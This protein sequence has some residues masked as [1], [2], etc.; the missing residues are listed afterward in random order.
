MGQAFTNSLEHIRAE[1]ARIRL[2][3]EQEIA[4][5]R[6]EHGAAAEEY[7][8]LYISEDEIDALLRDSPLDRPDGWTRPEL[9]DLRSRT[10][11]ALA[12]RRA[13]S[14][15]AGT[16]LRLEALRGRF[17]LSSFELE[18]LLVGLLPEA[19]LRE[20]RLYAY[21]QDDVTKKQ[22]SVQLA[23]RLLTSGLAETFAA[24]ASFLAGAPLL[25]HRLIRLFEDPSH[26]RTP[27]LGKLIKVEERV[28]SYLWGSDEPDERLLACCAA[29]P[30]RTEPEPLVV[31]PALEQRLQR[32]VQQWRP[33]L[34]RPPEGQPWPQWLYLWGPA[35][36][37]KNR[38]V[39]AACHQ[40]GLPLLHVN[41]VPLAA[42]E[43]GSE[44]VPLIVREGHLQGAALL[45]EGY[46][47]AGAGEAAAAELR[48]SL[49]RGLAGWM[50]PCFFTGDRTLAPH[51]VGS[52]PLV[53]WEV[54]LPDNEDRQ[55]LW[56]LYLDGRAGLGA[57]DLDEMAG[58]FR[59][60]GEQIRDV[61]AMAEGLAA[62][63]GANGKGPTIDDLLEASRAHS[64]Q[65]LGSLARKIQ[66]RFVW[67]DIVLPA[68]Q[69]AQLRE[70]V[71]LVRHRALVF[72]DWGFG[73]RMARNRGASVL[74]AG[75]P[76]TGKTMAAEIIAHELGLD[77]Y[78]VDLSTV[79]SKYIGETE[80]NLEKIFVEGETSNAILFFDEADA[81]FGKRSEV[82]D[83]HDRY[84]NVEVSYLLQ[85]MEEYEGI[86]ILATNLRKNLD[87][88]FTR[89]L[90]AAV[91]FP[92][93]EEP[94][95][96][97]I[98]RKVLPARAPLSADLDLEVLARR[99]KISG[100]NIRNIA[101]GAAFLA[102]AEE[103]PL[104]MDRL[105]RATKR[106]YQKMGKLL[107]AGA[108]APAEWVQAQREER[109]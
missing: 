108:L 86:V 59:L 33:L 10:A 98:W 6:Q 21:A 17:G 43:A 30:P 109:A 87:E 94:E 23:L 77:L 61:V 81:I 41:L 22:P 52:V 72:G 50:G 100:G 46:D 32:L 91:D 45:F 70:V 99:F 97:A 1:L 51:R 64:N 4:C 5:V 29:I 104:T 85:R 24:R 65:R 58:K 73:A 57:R 89:R 19:D 69:M 54:P 47:L 67:D 39:Q 42:A 9:A 88:A 105:L 63:R 95:R 27:L 34:G 107:E 60:S 35:G 102:A 80:K 11:A 93:P 18:V 26:A 3:L 49:Q 25:H 68:D 53:A 48:H 15:Q 103:G 31:G 83:S 2:L 75:P 82:R 20:A 28:A 92:L 12:E 55:R 79:V 38:L 96:L 36:T 16:E 101:L 14:L 8:G 37:G 66:P 71:A 13:A 56:R 40:L 84:A 78:K 74:F 76:G 44:L 62:G 106:E 90:Q 7:R